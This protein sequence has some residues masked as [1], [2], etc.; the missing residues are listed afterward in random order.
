MTHRG[1]R[2]EA[3]IEASRRLS[4]LSCSVGVFS[5]DGEKPACTASDA[6]V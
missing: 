6:R 5:S 2:G 4:V 3:L 1:N